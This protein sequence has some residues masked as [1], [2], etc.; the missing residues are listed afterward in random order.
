V[1]VYLSTGL[2]AL[3]ARMEPTPASEAAAIV[4]QAMKDP[5]TDTRV[6]DD[7][8]TGLVALAARMEPTQA[9]KL[10]GEAAAI[11]IQAMKDPKT[12]TSVLDNLSRALVALAAKLG[13]Q[14]ASE[15][16]RIGFEIILPV[17]A[18]SKDSDESDQTTIASLGGVPALQSGRFSVTAMTTVGG[19]GVVAFQEH[20]PRGIVAPQDLVDL[21]KHPLCVGK[22]QRLVLDQLENVYHRPF[23][24]KWDFVRFAPPGLDLTSPWRPVD[25]GSPR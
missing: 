21:L 4:I 15:A 14:E 3:A 9:S 23:A 6:L 11:V 18:K 1:V 10:C 2:V 19:L 8:S 24:D 25:S 13:P 5:K 12:S 22:P 7:L 17:I 20:P 16:C